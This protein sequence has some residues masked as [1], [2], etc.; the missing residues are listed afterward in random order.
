V[1]HHTPSRGL[2]GGQSSVEYLLILVLV[3]VLLIN[4]NLSPLEQFFDA[5]KHAYER[6][7]YAMSVL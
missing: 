6:F 3:A 7:T 5:I 1:K 2:C 4:G